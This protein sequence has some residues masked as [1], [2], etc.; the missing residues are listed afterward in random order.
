MITDKNEI[1]R[2]GK[3]YPIIISKYDPKWPKIFADEK[4]LIKKS[5]GAGNIE[6]ISHIGST[7]VKGMPAKPTIDILLEVRSDMKNSDIVAKL[8]NMGY[9]FDP[10]PQNPPPHMMFM[11]GYGKEG[12]TGQAYHIH[13]RYK[14]DWDELYF[15]DYL[16]KHNDAAKEYA[17]LKIRLKEKYEFNREAYTDGKTE[18]IRD[19]VKKARKEQK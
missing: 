13:V 8:T 18:F 5:L 12:F 10:Q 11:K 6:K 15:R 3:L 19:I 2:L 16:E 9:A 4:E 17:S 14:G 7:S 1:S